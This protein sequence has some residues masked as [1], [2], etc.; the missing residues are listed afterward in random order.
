LS[1]P[2]A[3]FIS[4]TFY[5]L[6]QIRE[7]LCEFI[8]KQLGYYALLSEKPS[9]PVDP[10]VRAVENCRGRVQDDADVFVLVIGG[11]YGSVDD[12]TAKSVTNLEYLAASAKGIPV[13]VFIDKHV[14]S[15]LAVWQD[16]KDADFSK[17]VDNIRLFDFI[18]RVR[19]TDGVWTYGFETA[20]EIVG[21][22]R[23][24][25]AY[26]MCA[27]LELSRRYRMRGDELPGDLSGAALRIAL[28]EPECWEYR[29]FG[30]VL[31]D[32]TRRYR[33]LRF[34]REWNLALGSVESVPL[35]E[36]PAWSIARLTELRHLGESLAT[37]VNEA[38]PVALGPPGQP[39]DKHGLIST[40]RHI[41][42]VY[43][44]AIEWQQ[45]VRRA[46][47]EA[48]WE[49]LSQVLAAF[50]DDLISKTENLACECLPK[51]ESAL[52]EP[53][54]GAPAV[55]DLTFNLEL[56]SMAE[57]DSEMDKLFRD[58]LG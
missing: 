41:A 7:D 39:G 44:S 4:S 36:T 31:L 34:Q 53:R 2:P 1:R 8:E 22:L 29:L 58:L 43:R 21:V 28:E 16:N 6:R 32:E 45:R 23:T 18:E 17:Q 38:L 57:F 13:Y 3:V 9:F 12:A 37:L 33:D 5:D 30:Q 24:Q 47:V 35:V 56:S 51:V 20:Q 27:G 52:A 15:L 10:D 19:S 49:R 40:A 46:H 11:R 48:E 14:L 54:G 42:E 26:L 50:A 25:L 55:V